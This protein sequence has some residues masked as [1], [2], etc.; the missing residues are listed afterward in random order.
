MRW[1][2]V[3]YRSYISPPFVPIFRKSYQCAGSQPTSLKFI[4]ILCPIHV[5]ASRKVSLLQVFPLK[6]CTKSH[7]PIRLSRS[8]Q[9]IY[10]IPRLSEE[11]LDRLFFYGEGLLTLR[12]TP[13]LEDHHLSAVHDCLFNIF[14]TIFH[15]WRSYTLSANWDR[16]MSWR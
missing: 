3:H 9:R 1:D 14:T 6:L 11:F 16:A 12:S 7:I 4:L 15:I 10:P 2:E 5:S 8:Y 13:K